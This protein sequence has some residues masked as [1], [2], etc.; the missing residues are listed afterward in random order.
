MLCLGDV[1]W[2]PALLSIEMK[3]EMG[4]G[5]SGLGGEERGE[6]MVEFLKY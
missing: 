2:R 4:N 6:T 5:W 1:L 3:E